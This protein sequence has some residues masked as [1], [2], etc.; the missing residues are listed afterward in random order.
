[1]SSQGAGAP[2]AAV[3]A[4]SARALASRINGA[5][6]LGPKTPE[7]KARSARNALKHGLRAERLILLDDEDPAEFEASVAAITAE[8]E[9][10]GAL[11]E[12]LAARVAMAAWRMRRV[13][14]LEAEILDERAFGRDRSAGDLALALTRDGNGARVFDTALR[15][16]GSVLA[17][18]WR[19]LRALKAL[20]AEPCLSSIQPRAARP[21]PP[22]EARPAR[23][24][25]TCDRPATER[26]C[27]GLASLSRWPRRRSASPRGVRQRGARA[28]RRSRAKPNAPAPWQP[29]EPEPAVRPRRPWCSRIQTASG[30]PEP[31]GKACAI[32]HLPGARY[33]LYPWHPAALRAKI[34][35][36][37]VRASYRGRRS[38]LRYVVHR[39]LIMVPT[40]LAISFITFVIIQLP[41]GDYLSSYIAELQAQGERIQ[42][43]KIEYLRQI[44]GLDK[45]WW[46]QYLVWLGGLFRGDFGYSFEYDLPVSAVVGDR[47]L[48]SFIVSFTTILFTWAVSFPIGVYSATHKYSVSDHVL[49]FIGFLGLATP[50]F[51][52]ALVLLYFANVVFGTSIGGLMD[53]DY[54]DQP[55]SWGKFVSVLAHLWVP[56]IV[57]GTSGT[58][59]MIRRLR[60]NLLDE[61]QKPYVVTA[62]A[63]GLHPFKALCEIPAAHGAQP[64]HRRH[65]HA[66]AFGHLG[67]R[68]GL[69]RALA[70]DHRAD[71][72]ARAAD[73]GHVPRRLLP[74]AAGAA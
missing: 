2:R 26:T 47:L 31:Q 62:K 40:L 41:P 35:V 66:A 1:M 36:R 21:A 20:Q 22:T 57:I 27:K 45:P 19:A 51:L 67:R 17:E 24:R 28:L 69:D 42:G 32:A 71:A 18:L 65:R 63:K 11:Q 23:A 12:Q 54:L 34:G 4:S 33:R 49:T 70:A 61:L 56:V 37:R 43:D 73:P 30:R 60:A 8:L 16:R 68:G 50:N 10:T 9:P 25:A 15:Y 48:L 14:R 64:V 55:M 74:D 38:L 29:N 58:A 72:A 52:L 44:Y 6:S 7:G 59:G 3:P 46:L 39:L 53:P 13:D 5:R